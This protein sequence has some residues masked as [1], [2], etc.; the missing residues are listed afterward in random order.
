MPT[1]LTRTALFYLAKPTVFSGD[2]EPASHGKY[3]DGASS[4][5]S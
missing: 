2:V 4:A 3:K 1:D 5:P